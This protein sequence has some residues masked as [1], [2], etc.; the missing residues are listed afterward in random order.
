MSGFLMHREIVCKGLGICLILAAAGGAGWSYCRQI[1]LRLEHIR[2]LQQLL[3]LLQGEIQYHCSTLPE[4]F[5]RCGRQGNGICGQWLA[6]TGRRLNAME[7]VGF[8]E[9]WE[10]QIGELQKT[11]ALSNANIEDL[12]RLGNRLSY[13]D[14]DTQ[15]GA[16]ELYSQRLKEQEEQLTRELPVKMKLGTTLGI[17]AG[18]FLVILLI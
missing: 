1:R 14:K 11:T 10:Q 12:K 7:G 3:L 16:M 6:E 8:Q 2:Q 5:E 15:L 4:A 17:L 13:P 18:M 9:L